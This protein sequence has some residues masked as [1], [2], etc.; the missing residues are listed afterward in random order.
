MSNSNTPSKQDK[1][2]ESYLKIANWFYD[3]SGNAQL[4]EKHKKIFERWSFADSLIRREY[5]DERN[6]P[7]LLV[8]KYPDIGRSTAYED[9]RNAK[10]L[11]GS[12]NLEDQLY[13]SNVHYSYA[14][15]MFK[16]AKQKGQ[17]KAAEG[18]LKIMHEIKGSNMDSLQDE[19]MRELAKSVENSKVIYITTNPETV[20]FKKYDPEHVKKLKE[21]LYRSDEFATDAEVVK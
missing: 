5:I 9:I 1:Y 13:Y 15:D 7:A 8:K 17:L 18:F 10:K 19:A 21:E 6:I 11:F 16:L 20:G 12:T 3:Q 2:N 14:L 4:D